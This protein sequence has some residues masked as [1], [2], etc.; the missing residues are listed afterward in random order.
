MPVSITQTN[1]PIWGIY[2]LQAPPHPVDAAMLRDNSGTLPAD[3]V[4]Q[5]RVLFNYGK[6]DSL[7]DYVAGV[8]PTVKT[9][10][11]GATG[12]HVRSIL[13]NGLTIASGTALVRAILTGDIPADDAHVINADGVRNAMAGDTADLDDGLA[14]F[15]VQG[16]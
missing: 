14:S 1:S 4:P 7:D 6:Y 11:F 12:P 15:V 9:G 8:E 16:V 13:E 2:D 10:M 5:S 3:Y